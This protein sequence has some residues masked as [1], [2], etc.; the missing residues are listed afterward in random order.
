METSVWSPDRRYVNTQ[1]AL[2]VGDDSGHGWPGH[3]GHAET[4]HAWCYPC[5]PRNE[6]TQPAFPQKGE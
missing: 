6:R 5:V 4:K 1:P 2:D 3:A